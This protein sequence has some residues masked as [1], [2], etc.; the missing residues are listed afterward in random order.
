MEFKG[1][2]ALVTGASSGMGEVFAR[3]LARRG[4]NLVLAARSKDKLEALA[5]ELRA[6]AHGTVHVEAADLA[7]PGAAG[8]WQPGS[9]SRTCRSTCWSTMRG[10]GCSARCM[11]LTAS[12][13]RRRFS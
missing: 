3:E 11:R 8:R 1:S 4:A 6:R 9:R 10:S 5:S 12:G 7:E 2:R 13:S